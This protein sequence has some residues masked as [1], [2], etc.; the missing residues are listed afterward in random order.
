MN[1]TRL[2]AILSRVVV[3]WIIVSPVRA[4]SPSPA[5]MAEARS[6]AEKLEGS[7]KS[8]GI[9]PFFSFTYDGKPS[10]ELLGQWEQKR[11]TRQLDEHRTER[12]LTWTDP[13][14]G[15]EIRRTSVIYSDFPVVEWTVYFKN[16]GKADTPILADIQGMDVSFQRSGEGDYVLRSIRGDDC[17]AASYQ[18]IVEN[19]SKGASHRFA[20]AGGRP[21]QGTFPYFNVEWSGQGVIAV[22]GWP[23]QWA[24]QFDCDQSSVLKIRGGQELT[25]LKLLPG[26]EIRTPL[27]VLMF[28]KGDALRSQNLWRRW[29]IVHNIPRINGKV[30]PVF[31]SSMGPSGIALQPVADE[32]IAAIDAYQKAGAKFDYWWIDAGWYPCNGSWT[33]TGTWEPDPTRFPKGI[34]PVSDH[35]RSK[36]MKFVLWF[37]PERVAP[38]S[39]LTKNHPQWIFGGEG[40]GLLNMGNPEARKCVTEH[41]SRLIKE[42]G[43]DL[44]RE[45]FNIDPLGYWRRNDAPD[46]QG[47][48]E[49]LYVQG[50]LAYW[51]EL[52]RRFPDNLIDSCASGGRRNDLETLR[53]AVPLL[54]SD[55][56]SASQPG[57][58]AAFAGS[59][60]QTYGLS[61]W[62]PYFGVGVSCEDAYDVRSHITP[63]LGMASS[64]FSTNKG[65]ISPELPHRIADWRAVA[66]EFYGDYYPLTK[67]S[68]SEDAW[69]AWQFNR[70]EVGSGMVQAFRHTESPYESIRVKLQGL[71][72]D[73]VYALTNLDVPGTIEISGSELSETGLLIVLKDQRGSALIT[74][75]KKP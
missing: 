49:N 66:P 1:M 18:P 55:F 48:T 70:P 12:T 17:S 46:R 72:K 42:Q 14:T 28:W 45:D 73:A 30:P 15:L 68:L 33:N 16:T 75:K 43:V 57:N 69:M 67:Y 36:G 35:A 23:G 20:S 29:M 22:L 27:S 3:A 56:Y 10:A 25:K 63:E 50:H 47:I 60:G 74:Y 6:W 19:F 7:A 13:K 58:P 54:R 11:T 51:D 62:V 52:R 5:E 8:K 38:G 24:T 32:E 39:W 41:F 2:C 4:V 9:E 71:D 65:P 26:E 59:Q 53:R 64:A 37:E 44:Y 34:K 31:L 21:T 61:F 40:G